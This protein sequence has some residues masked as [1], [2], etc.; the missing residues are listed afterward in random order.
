MKN[1]G[2]LLGALAAAA[3]S[4]SAHADTTPETSKQDPALEE[5]TVTARKRAESL[6]N[7]P[8][9]V[10]VFTASEIAAAGIERP[11]DFVQMTPNVTLVQTQN[12]GTSFVVI[13]GISQA[14]N[15][16]P[17]VAVLIDGVQ[18]ANPSQFNQELYDIE[19]IEVLKG[20]QGALYGRDAIGGA[21][22]IDTKQ[23]TD[24]LEGNV[25]LGYDSGPGYKVRGD[26]SGPI[27]GTD[28]F[29]FR[30]SFSIFNTKGYIENSYLH[31]KADP[32]RDISARANL[33][34]Q[35]STDFN[36]DLRFSM[37]HV[38]TQAVYYSVTADANTIAPIQ[39]NN[40]GIDRRD[41]YDTSLKLDYDTTFGRFTSITAFDSVE[42]FF[43]GDQFNDLPITQSILYLLFG[44]DQAQATFLKSQS[45]S[46]E[47]RFTSPTENRLRWIAGAYGI[48]TDRFIS[49]GNVFD[50]GTGIPEIT[51]SPLPL[52]NPQASWLADQQYN[53]AWAGFA[54]LSYDITDSL[55]GTV[56]LRYDDDNRKNV[57]K[58]PTQF[59][60]PELAGSAYPGQVR[61]RSWGALQP[62]FTLRYKFTPDI[63]TYAD[64]GRG[65][66]SGG[67][68]Q[69]GVGA[70]GIPGIKDYF[71][72]ELADTAELGVKTQFLER[73]IGANVAVYHTVDRGAYFFVYDPITGTQNLGNLGRVIYKGLEIETNARVVEGFDVHADVGFT[74]SNIR[75][76]DRAPTDVGHQTSLVSKYTINIGG[77]YRYPLP[78]GNG[79]S[80]VFRTDYERIGPTYWFPDNIA[81]RNPID[82]VNLRIGV[83]GSAWSVT[84]WSKNLFDK[85]YNAEWAPGPPFPGPP[86]TNSGV[87]R[88]EPRVWGVDFKYHFGL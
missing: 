84:A 74:N 17:S 55:E 62:K 85:I 48:Y 73:R 78:W 15:S 40:P 23:P 6:I 18:L 79:L 49:T 22:I 59:I 28:T 68:N 64:Y 50:Y 56:A 43:D 33:L 1:V 51:Y 30:T 35:P 88:A 26:L 63:V 52:Y 25:M 19:H 10:S 46:Q 47:L 67:F 61:Q 69:T 71:D 58:T 12:Q 29:K 32:F 77:Q 75:E 66:R 8:V 24:K 81:V 27:G 31:E 65:F 13:R 82:L 83:E 54:D 9:A 44:H 2:R 36:A 60:P 53:F 42:E 5:I 87:F 57:T 80:A 11:Q 72:K 16:E 21:I 14:R 7:V 45:Y 39:V 4:F 38:I 3:A 70:A 76:S 37:S 41:L 86:G 34:W 20:P